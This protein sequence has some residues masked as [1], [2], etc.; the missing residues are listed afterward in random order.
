[1]K[2]A[3]LHKNAE[4]SGLDS[5]NFNQDINY[6]VPRRSAIS[7]LRVNR[8]TYPRHKGLAHASASTWWRW[9]PSGALTKA[10][11]IGPNVTCWDLAE[12]ELWLESFDNKKIAH[13]LRKNW[14]V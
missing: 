7:V 10:I 12:I 3:R 6:A 8:L 14:R 4:T 2:N 9:T 1:M 13:P 11:R 5:H